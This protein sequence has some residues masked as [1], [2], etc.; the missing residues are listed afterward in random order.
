MD[1]PYNFLAGHGICAVEPVFSIDDIEKWNQVVDPILA[2][3]DL[4][5]RYVNAQQLF[6]NGLLYAIFNKKM[7]SLIAHLLPV[8]VLY[9]CHIYEIDGNQSKSHIRTGDGL[10]GWHR[11]EE[12]LPYY[13]PGKPNTISIFIYLTDVGTDSGPFEIAN[14]PPQ[15]FWNRIGGKP[16]YKMVGGRSYTFIFD[17]TYIHRAHPNSDP[18]KRRVLKLSIQPPSIENKR[19]G[20]PEYVKVLQEIKG[21]DI[22]LEHLFGGECDQKKYAEIVAMYKKFPHPNS[23]HL[24]E[25]SSI[26]IGPLHE[27]E[28]RLTS[29]L[30]KIYKVI[31]GETNGY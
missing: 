9:H 29:R 5:R 27:L 26:K 25:N 1:S 10:L 20:L 28:V 6:E 4:A 16:C 8:S 21:K 24:E 11:D 19:I 12:C 17:R 31:K 18:I 13:V 15:K 23:L 30:R 14:Y 7:R 22:F 2:S 3:Q